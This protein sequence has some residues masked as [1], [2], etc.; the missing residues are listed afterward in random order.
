MYVCVA[1][2]LRAWIWWSE[3]EYQRAS[4]WF[5]SESFN[6]PY[7]V[8]WAGHDVC[9]CQ[10]LQIFF[11]IFKSFGY[12]YILFCSHANAKK[13]KTPPRIPRI[14]QTP[15]LMDVGPYPFFF[16]LL[17]FFDRDRRRRRRPPPFCGQW[18]TDNRWILYYLDKKKLLTLGMQ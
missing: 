7:R 16:F 2:P 11:F 6:K 13:K 12:F 10:T 4:R 3:C 5:W 9:A 15:W 1:A 18:R 8:M 17:P 14:S